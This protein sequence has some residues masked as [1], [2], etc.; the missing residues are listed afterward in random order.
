MAL[1]TRNVVLLAKIESTE[2]VDP[3]PDKDV[4]SILVINPTPSIQADELR[5]QIAVGH[6]S[7]TGTV[8]ASILII[9]CAASRML[10]SGDAT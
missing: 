2:G 9:S 10:C 8:P 3:T 4:D 1:L 6:L 7:P 5:R